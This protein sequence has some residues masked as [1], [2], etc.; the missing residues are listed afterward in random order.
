MNFFI[1]FHKLDLG[2]RII[3]KVFAWNNNFIRFFCTIWCKVKMQLWDIKY[4]KGCEFRGTT[5][6]F[7]GLGS[8]ITLGNCCRFNSNSRFNF[9][10]INHHCILQAIHG[11]K[12]SIGDRFGA[13]GVSIVSNVD[14]TIG[15]DVMCGANVKIGDRNGHENRYPEWQP[16]P[17]QIGNNVWIGMNSIVMRGVTI[18]DNVVIGANSVVTKDIPSNA[19]AAGNPC[20]VIRER[21]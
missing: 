12:I 17:I 18:G 21:K 3:R 10:G 20:K 9:R 8:S 11:G 4:G 2:G 1:Y 13:S 16:K 19:V 7:R 5:I 14:V 6:F 15:N